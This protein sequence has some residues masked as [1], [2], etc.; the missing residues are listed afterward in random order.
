MPG[1][2][3]MPAPYDRPANAENGAGHALVTGPLQAAGPLPV[4]Q[5][6]VACYIESI[7][8]ELR[9]MAMA[10]RLDTLAYFL[11]MVRIEASVQVAERADG[12]LGQ[13]DG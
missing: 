12:V 6:S 1:S 10:V 3:P 11:E 9:V 8:A 5:L 4:T 13:S 7:A 2:K